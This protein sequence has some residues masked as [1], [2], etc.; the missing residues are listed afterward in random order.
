MRPSDETDSLLSTLESVRRDGF[1]YYFKL[2]NRYCPA[3]PAFSFRKRRFT[4]IVKQ[5]AL[6]CDSL[7][8]QSTSNLV[9]LLPCASV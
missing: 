9:L 1:Y 2:R 7:F 4:A 3:F 8:N 6:V 5:V